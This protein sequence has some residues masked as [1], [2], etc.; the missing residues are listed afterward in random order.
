[1]SEL[2][3]CE[4]CGEEAEL[5]QC[6]CPSCGKEYHVCELCVMDLCPE[7]ESGEV[8]EVVNGTEEGD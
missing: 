3:Y 6:V 8:M 5:Q 2:R 7:C 1:M 4:Y